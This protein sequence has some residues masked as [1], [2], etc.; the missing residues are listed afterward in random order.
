MWLWIGIFILILI[1]F[2]ILILIFDPK[3][4]YLSIDKIKKWLGIEEKTKK[5]KHK[6]KKWIFG[7]ILIIILILVVPRLFAIVPAG[8]VGIH[9]LFGQVETAER[10]P[11]L[12]FKNPLAEIV[13]M[14]VKTQE[15]T[16]STVIGEGAKRGS[17]VIVALTKEGLSVS[18]DMTVLYRLKPDWASDVYKT[19]GTDYINIIVRPQIRT[20]IR[21]IVAKYEAKQIYSE[22]RE[23]I[24]Q[25]I[26][27]N[28]RPELIKRGIILERV[29]LRHVQLPAELTRAIEAKLTAEQEIEKK[30]FEVQREQEEAFRKI[31]EAEGIA[32]AT[33][34][35]Q[36]SLAEAP[37]YLTWVWLQKLEYHDS[38]VYVLEGKMGIPLFKDIDSPWGD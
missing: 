37:E 13:S 25:E 32:N 19:I 38:V 3:T 7:I 21:E 8:H 29:L 5:K 10:K 26:F 35:I 1:I 9:D 6:I 34:V 22:E 12:H 30:R 23:A 28:L 17:D 24:A 20:V 27:D 16:M 4:D 33:K 15:Y 18:L 36:K 31:V 2:F 11:G 14:S